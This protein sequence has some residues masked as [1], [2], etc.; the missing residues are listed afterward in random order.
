MM[1]THNPQPDRIT[2]PTDKYDSCTCTVL[3][4]VS[5]CYTSI[6]GKYDGIEIFTV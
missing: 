3:R 6:P 5:P 4:L 2:D 1:L